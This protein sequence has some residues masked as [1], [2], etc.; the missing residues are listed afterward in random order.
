MVRAATSNKS[1]ISCDLGVGQSKTTTDRK[2]KDHKRTN[3]GREG[4]RHINLKIW[5]EVYP[6]WEVY[7][8]IP[9]S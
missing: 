1:D 4:G 6:L 3:K 7:K 5:D 2:I 8:G 9:V